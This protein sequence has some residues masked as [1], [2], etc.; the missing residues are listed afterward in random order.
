MWMKNAASD[1]RVCS[2]VCGKAWGSSPRSRLGTPNKFW[3][4]FEE[5]LPVLRWCWNSWW[6][7]LEIPIDWLPINISFTAITRPASR[8]DLSCKKNKLQHKWSMIAVVQPEQ[9]EALF[10]PGNGATSGITVKTLWIYIY[11]LFTV[12]VVQNMPEDLHCH[13]KLA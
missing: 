1:F 2:K 12:W 8:L 5:Q 4:V 7:I 13:R 9:E 10:T 3:R 11:E 6:V